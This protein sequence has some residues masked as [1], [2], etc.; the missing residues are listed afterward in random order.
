MFSIRPVE[1][2]D[3][4]FVK[5]LVR[6]RWDGPTVVVH[7]ECLLPDRLPG[8]IAERSAKPVGLVT[9]RICTGSCEIVTLDALERASGIGTALIAA[10]IETARQAHCG[11]IW[12]VTTNDNIDALRFY[13]R[14][15]F[16]LAAV[17]RNAVA[18]SRRI[19]PDIPLLGCYGIAIRDEIEL[20]QRLE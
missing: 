6:E 8:F 20:E 1:P 9:F 14:R 15:G 4:Q 19:K 16:V 13:Q 3:V 2:S 7:G 18:A 12:L 11:R 5:D 10:M 17:H